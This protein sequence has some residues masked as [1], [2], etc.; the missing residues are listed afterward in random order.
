MDDVRVVMDAAGSS[1]ATLVSYLEGARLALL[2]AATYPERVDGLVLVDPW[3]RLTRSDEHPWG[4]GPDDVRTSIGEIARRWGDRDFFHERFQ[5]VFSTHANDAE[6]EEWWIRH[7]RRGATPASA[8]A[9]QR[10]VAG[11]DVTEVL[12]S[13]AAPVV[14]IRVRESDERVHY[15]TDRLADARIINA[16]GAA[17]TPFGAAEEQVLAELEGLI[18]GDEPVPTHRVLTTVLFTDVVRSTTRASALGD[19][20]WAQLLERHHA[21]VRRELARHRGSEVDT[22]GDG[23]FASFD[24]PGRAIRCAEAIIDGVRE[25]GLDVRAGVHTGECEIAAGKIAGNAVVIGARVAALAHPGE[26]LATRTVKDL[27]A[28]SDIS[29]EDRGEHELAGVPG[30]WRL[31]ATFAG[32]LPD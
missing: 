32:R 31:Y 5:E 9:W 3:V 29:F 28:G 17:V 16:V 11:A 1:R 15:L 8:A 23:F 20:H 27:V 19:R 21:L 6:L 2:F 14:V 24:G 13:V 18:S 22:A 12:S 4:L 26:V 10:G 25:L 30:S 7:M